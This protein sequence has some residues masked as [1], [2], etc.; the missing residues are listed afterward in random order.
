MSVFGPWSMHIACATAYNHVLLFVG[1][2]M[3][4]HLKILFCNGYGNV[5]CSCVH[6]KVESLLLWVLQVNVQV[7]VEFDGGF[8]AEFRSEFRIHVFVEFRKQFVKTF[9]W[10]PRVDSRISCLI[11]LTCF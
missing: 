10:E 9:C 3:C 4:A 8:D 7:R 1:L 11:S 5:A 2:F 6:L